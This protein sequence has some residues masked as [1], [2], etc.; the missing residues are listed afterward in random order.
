MP[1]LSEYFKQKK[2]VCL[3]FMTVDCY[4]LNTSVSIVQEFLQNVVPQLI[5]LI[6]QVPK[7]Q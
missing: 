7:I 4:S 3:P 2:N 1:Y 5:R 6:A